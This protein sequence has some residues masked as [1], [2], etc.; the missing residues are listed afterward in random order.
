V[1]WGKAL[2]DISW[3]NRNYFC[4]EGLKPR[5][6]GQHEQSC[7]GRRVGRNMRPKGDGGPARRKMD[8][9]G[10]N[11]LDSRRHGQG[12]SNIRSIK[13]FEDH[14]NNPVKMKYSLGFIEEDFNKE[15]RKNIQVA[16]L[17]N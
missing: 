7:P 2:G 15:T 14:N 16:E 3:K 9:S 13:D 17:D 10:F 12:S 5:E 8:E 11:G 6:I 1:D 4:T